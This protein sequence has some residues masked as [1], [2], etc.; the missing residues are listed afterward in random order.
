MAR[1]P[2]DGRQA[3]AP[4]KVKLT[5]FTVTKTKPQSTV[6]NVWDSEQKGLVLQIQPSG[7]RSFRCCYSRKGKPYWIHLADATAIG[8]AQARQLANEVMFH[9]AQGRHPYAERRAKRDQGSFKQLHTRYLEEH[10]Q[11]VNKSW[12][13]SEAL[14]NRYTKKIADTDATE[15]SREDIKGLVKDL[16]PMLANQVLA[17]ISAVFNWGIREGVVVNNPAK[18]ITRNPTKP[19][20]RILSDSELPK[21]WQEFEKLPGIEGLLLKTILLTGQRPGECAHMRWEHII[22]G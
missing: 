17:A 4:N 22:D 8:L 11:K 10:A 13:Q 5:E 18:L 1:P 14:I 19:R 21:F 3:R 9:V 12:A 15:V 6:L 7:H 20:Q 2:R 16:K